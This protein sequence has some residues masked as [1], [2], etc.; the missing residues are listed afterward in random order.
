MSEIQEDEEEMMMRARLQKMKYNRR[1]SV[2]A[3]G[4]VR[5]RTEGNIVPYNIGAFFPKP[6]FF[7][8]VP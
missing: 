7:I 8:I 5:L 1:Q 4:Y 6:P 3:E 2:S